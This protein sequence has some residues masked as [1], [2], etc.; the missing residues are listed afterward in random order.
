MKSCAF[1]FF[2]VKLADSFSS[3]WQFPLWEV[4][5]GIGNRHGH[6]Y[7]ELH[8]ISDVNSPHTRPAWF[9]GTVYPQ[10]PYT[11]CVVPREGRG[12][13]SVHV[14]VPVDLIDMLDEYATRGLILSRHLHHRDIDP[15]LAT[16]RSIAKV[17]DNI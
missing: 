2:S 12:D 13:I 11:S 17:A 8:D 5:F 16:C 4:D 10:A 14:T 7:S 3:S 15:T 6:E 9:S 1:P